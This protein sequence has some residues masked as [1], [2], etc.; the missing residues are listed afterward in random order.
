VKELG[1]EQ[2]RGGKGLYVRG[3]GRLTAWSPACAR[4]PS[5]GVWQIEQ[6]RCL[7]RRP[8]YH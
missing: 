4:S 7:R 2:G 1:K 6:S 5:H 8:P 3:E